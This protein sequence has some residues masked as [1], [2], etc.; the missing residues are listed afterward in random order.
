MGRKEQDKKAKRALA[1]T[2]HFVKRLAAGSEN[3][4]SSVSLGGVEAEREPARAPSPNPA[5]GSGNPASSVSSG[6][7]EAALESA[8]V[9]P[10]N[11]AT[12]DRNP[13]R[14]VIVGGLGSEVKVCIP[15][16]A[17]GAKGKSDRRQWDYDEGKDGKYTCAECG[18]KP[19]RSWF[20]IEAT[21]GE[22]NL[23]CEYD[24]EG[25][26]YG[27]CYF[28]CRG[29]GEHAGA[30][31][32]Y[33]NLLATH[34]EEQLRELFRK[35]CNKRHGKRSDVKKNEHAQLKIKE[36]QE[37]LD[38]IVANYPDMSMSKR[39]RQCF[40]FCKKAAKDA[41][42]ALQLSDPQLCNALQEI[43]RKYKERKRSQAEEGDSPGI[44]CSHPERTGKEVQYLHK[45]FPE[46]NRFFICR[47]LECSDA[48]SFYGYNT[49]WISTCAQGGWKF[50]CPHCAYPYSMNL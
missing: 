41:H 48:G 39:R 46:T 47:N 21:D 45:I 19:V 17:G 3:P 14:S 2:N 16:G 23:C 28:C 22:G 8:R 12:G 50:A 43:A 24:V 49:D 31:D 40:D 34:S 35:E 20:L 13:A 33:E 4:A 6:G 32:I 1:A 11:T 25:R 44:P 5:A 37:L 10:P 26:L 38:T 30:K 15:T 27:R 42:A 7:V 9:A 18:M 29:L 36:W